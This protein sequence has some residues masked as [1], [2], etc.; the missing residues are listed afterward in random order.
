MQYF[1]IQEWVK[2]NEITVRKVHTSINVADLMTKALS[3]KLH[4]RH[5]NRLMGYYGRPQHGAFIAPSTP[6]QAL[7]K[8]QNTDLSANSL[9][10]G[11][12]MPTQFPTYADST[13]N[14]LPE[15]PLS[16]TPAVTALPAEPFCVQPP[17]EQ[18][19]MLTDRLG[20][21]VDLI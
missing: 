21:Y 16:I 6:L 3:A 18:E 9:S 20:S 11:Q 17:F 7:C 1:A 8:T 10:N 5:M 4:H 12:T 13:N 14:I 19:G 2:N 15:L